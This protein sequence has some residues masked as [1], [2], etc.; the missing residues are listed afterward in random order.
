MEAQPYKIDPEKAEKIYNKYKKEYNEKQNTI[1]F[2]EH[3]VNLLIIKELY[4][5]L[6]L[7]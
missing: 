1:F 4:I 2:T 6:S 3:K 5:I 7:E